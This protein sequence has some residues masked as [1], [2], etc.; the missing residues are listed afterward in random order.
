M[1]IK[2][3]NYTVVPSG[4]DKGEVYLSIMPY[5][6]NFYLLNMTTSKVAAIQGH[7]S[8][9]T[10]CQFVNYSYVMTCGCDQIIGLKDIG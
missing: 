4:G 1:D 2:K 10:Q 5:S 3:M 9:V 7:K 8:Y 6:N